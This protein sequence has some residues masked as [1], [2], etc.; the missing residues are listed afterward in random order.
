M[1]SDRL[2]EAA[3]LN[4]AVIP[5]RERDRT[6]QGIT[7]RIQFAGVPPPTCLPSLIR[8]ISSKSIIAGVIPC[9]AAVGQGARLP[10]EFSSTARIHYHAAPWKRRFSHFILTSC[11]SRHYHTS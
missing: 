11:S 3:Q 4:C 7:P 10:V 2:F 1:A 9:Y 8:P 5:V 6:R